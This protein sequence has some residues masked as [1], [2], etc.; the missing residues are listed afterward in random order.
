MDQFPEFRSNPQ[1]GGAGSGG[2]TGGTG[3]G[4]ED[5]GVA[6]A[7]SLAKQA[8]QADQSAQKARAAIFGAPAAAGPAAE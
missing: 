5:P 8:N 2:S 1:A 3:G 4:K 6:L 7:K